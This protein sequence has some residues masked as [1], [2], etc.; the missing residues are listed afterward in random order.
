MQL[1]LLWLLALTV[2]LAQAGPAEPSLLFGE[3][4]RSV[5]E[6]H[7]ALKA[8]QL[9]REAAAAW[10]RGAGAQPNP[11][12]RLS[13]PYGYPSEE[14]N[15]LVQRIELGGQPGLRSKIA[16][17]QRDQADAR[18]LNQQRELGKQAA[19]AY[20]SLWAASETERLETARVE[21]ADKLQSAAARRL[22][23]GEISENQFLR[24]E[25]E[26][27]QSQARLATAQA[28]RR[29]ALNR[30][31]LLLQRPPDQEVAL[32]AA[33]QEILPEPNRELLLAAVE[34]RPEVR[35]AQLSAEIQRAEAELV[36]RQRV[37][38]FEFEAYRSSL[39]QGA[40]QGVR[41]S[42]AFPLW[43][44]GQTGAAV[45]QHLRE[46]EAA[47]SDALANR[48]IALN[49]LNLLLQRPPDQ[50]VALPAADQEILPEPNRELLLAAVE[51]RPEVRVAQ[52]SAEIQ[53]AEAELVGRQRV[54]DFEFE[55]YRSSLAQ[56]AEQGVRVSLAF[57]LW[58]WG[59]TGAAVEQHLR[60]AEAAESDA[61]AQRQSVTQ[62]ALAAWESLLGEQKRRELLRGQVERFGRQADLTRRGYEDRKSVV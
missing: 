18:V 5:Q 7:P 30:L 53:R 35:V 16:N 36:G 24:V 55:A 2:G 29:I 62:E 26:K 1:H 14:A 51:L 27:S 22:K 25:L 61:L 13:V 39:A 12:L 3:V 46:A 45:E 52:L 43:D 56:G 44:W 31:N 15:A 60:E 54:P 48:R 6:R 38:D 50:E 11:Q 21:L 37:P 9:R 19:L 42:L 17:L 4:L 28:N 33:D 47:E 32:P 41:V 59:Q 57:P 58:D 34:L 49:R 40:E 8:A 20:Y 23:L 10:A